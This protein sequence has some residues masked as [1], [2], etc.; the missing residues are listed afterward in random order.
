MNSLLLQEQ[1]I[2]TFE[3]SLPGLFLGMDTFL[4]P[5]REFAV[6]TTRGRIR[7]FLRSCLSIPSYKVYNFPGNKLLAYLSLYKPSAGW[8]VHRPQKENAHSRSPQNETGLSQKPQ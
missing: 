2:D 1:I 7:R 4:L 6:I 3:I 8:V 5:Q